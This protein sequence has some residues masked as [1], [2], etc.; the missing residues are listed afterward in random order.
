MATS[1]LLGPVRSSWAFL[2]A[3]A[4]GLSIEKEKQ[5]GEQFLLEIQ[6]EVPLIQDPFLT[7]YI[8]NLGQKLVAQMG[9]Q[10][11]H[12]RFFIIDD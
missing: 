6:Q 8:N 2:D 1:L 4:G 10:P 12:Y 11:F 7:S 9:P 5:I 3:L